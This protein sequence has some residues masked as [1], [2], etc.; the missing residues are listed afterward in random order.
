MILQASKNDYI[1]TILN[2]L[3]DPRP[4]VQKGEKGTILV[5]NIDFFSRKSS[6]QTGSIRDIISMVRIAS[7]IVTQNAQLDLVLEKEP[8]DLVF[9]MYMLSNR[10]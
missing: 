9:T 8:I 10:T 4:N 5:T 7:V 3:V 1:I 6:L 2:E